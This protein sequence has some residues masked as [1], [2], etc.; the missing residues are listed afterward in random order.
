MPDTDFLVLDILGGGRSELETDEVPDARAIRLSAKRRQERV[1]QQQ[2][3]SEVIAS[4]SLCGLG[5]SA[6]NPVMSTIR[7]FQEEYRKHIEE[8]KCPAGVCQ[9]LITYT[10]NEKCT[11]CLLCGKV[12]PVDAVAGEKKKLHVID[13]E[14]CTRCGAC[15]AVC[16]DDAI[17]VS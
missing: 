12:C 6:P 8:K 11:G 15:I 2:A 7:Y 9:A 16:P 13:Q 17:D 14:A 3:L 10:I 4:A 5:Q 1:L